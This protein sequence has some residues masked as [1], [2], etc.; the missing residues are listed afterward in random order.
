MHHSLLILTLAILL[1]MLI[2]TAPL[3]GYGNPPLLARSEP[4]DGAMGVPADLE[5]IRLFFSQDMNTRSHTIWTSAKGEMPPLVEGGSSWID[6]RTFQLE[7]LPL[8]PGKTYAIQLNSRQRLG[9][10]SVSGEPLPVTTIVFTTSA[11]GASASVSSSACL[12]GATAPST[13]RPDQPVRGHN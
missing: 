4:A 10:E 5:V 12:P 3:S 9:F 6:A 2:G 13:A 11:A 1:L 7:L 8:K